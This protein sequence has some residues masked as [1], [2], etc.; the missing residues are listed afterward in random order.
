M[1]EKLRIYIAI[2][3]FHPL[4]GGAESQ[5]LA[6]CQRLQEQGHHVQIVTF[7]H[8]H[9]WLA[10][11]M[12]ES[13]PVM[14]IA[15]LLLGRRAQMPRLLQ[16]LMYMFAMLVMS[17]T[18]WRESKKYDILHV[19]QLSMLCLPLAMVCRLTRKPMAIVLI[20]AGSGDA[21]KK[22]QGPATLLAGPLDPHTPW[23]KVEGP[24]WIDGDIYSVVANG[25]LFMGMLRHLL[26][27]INAVL[28]VLS[29]R[30]LNDL[31]KTNLCLPG[32]HIIPNGVDGERFHLHPCV[33]A[34]EERTQTVVCVAKL[35]YEKGIDVL[36][37]AWRV[38]QE[39]MP[40]SRLVIV[41]D[42]PIEQQ[43]KMLAEALTIAQSIDFTGLQSNI[44]AQLHRGLIA[45]LPS[46]WEGMPNAL[47]EA[48]AC[49][50]ACVATRVSGSEDLIE[51]GVNGL[52]V[53]VEHYKS[54]AQELL[55]LL[56]DPEL[57]HQYGR[58]ARVKI[59]KYYMIE[60]ISDT[61]LELYHRMV[62]EKLVS[63][64]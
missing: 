20:S 56:R 32:T 60:K 2:T 38:V 33:I 45:V 22:T 17:W 1:Q 27:S 37:Q 14:R 34:D 47:L 16:R 43:H 63:A 62:Q 55:V 21:H 8:D 9:R 13:V 57:A 46:R 15:G 48:M 19:C 10:S 61:Y 24:S 26:L 40:E 49:G 59:E 7:R 52:L 41:G 11:E 3:T 53:D 12:I 35:R 58:A 44:P 31:K 25:K 64:S 6:Q 30:M 39:Q 50:C 51:H 29:S 36:L 42:G 18:L 28:I 5:T 54:M 23:L 4:I